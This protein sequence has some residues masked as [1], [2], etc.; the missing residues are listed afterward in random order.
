M[1]EETDI[2]VS[3]KD[4]ANARYY[5]SAA[6]ACARAAVEIESLRKEI[7]LLRAILR[8]HCA[9]TITEEKYE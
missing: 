5:G 9:T 7:E 4:F 3:L 1:I 2:L 6:N 8:N